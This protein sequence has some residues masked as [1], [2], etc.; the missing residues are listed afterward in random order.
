M[1][2]MDIRA[3]S[4]ENLPA[5]ATQTVVLDVSDGFEVT[6]NNQDCHPV[7]SWGEQNVSI[8]GDD[9]FTY[10]QISPPACAIWKMYYGNAQR[11]QTSTTDELYTL[12]KDH[13][14]S[15]VRVMN[16]GDVEVLRYGVWG[17][18]RSQAVNS[19]DT[20]F[21]YTGQEKIGQPGVT[22]MPYRPLPRIG[23]GSLFAFPTTRRRKKSVI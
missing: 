23:R 14:G 1:M 17:E 11:I 20:D 19:L 10:T 22:E 12:L 6:L 21:L 7:N 8:F 15:T 4:L 2:E 16:N 5:S 18:A 9:D 3:I 13:L